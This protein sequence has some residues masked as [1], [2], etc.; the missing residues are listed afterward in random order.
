MADFARIIR[1][2]YREILDREPDPAGLA[3]WNS[4]MRAGLTEAQLREALLRSEEYAAANPGGGVGGT[5]HD[6]F[7]L[8]VAGNGLI[9]PDGTPVTFRGAIPCCTTEE[10]EANPEWPLA[11]AAFRAARA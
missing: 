11:S 6:E 10:G 8:R 5:R 9:L 7:L 2:A 4:Q 3:H 1:E